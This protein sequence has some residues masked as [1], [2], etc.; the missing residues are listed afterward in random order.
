[1]CIYI[2]IYTYTHIHCLFI[3][4]GREREREREREI[5]TYHI[6]RPMGLEPRDDDLGSAERSLRKRVW[7]RACV[8]ASSALRTRREQQEYLYLC[9][10]LY[11]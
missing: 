1:M 11:L 4:R 2:Y 9:L 5:H 7:R 10:Y 3:K 8:L 6:W